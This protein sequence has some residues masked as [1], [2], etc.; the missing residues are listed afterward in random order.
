VLDSGWCQ[1]PRFHG[2][3]QVQ[4]VFICSD[5]MISKCLCN[6]FLAIKQ[7]GRATLACF[8][9]NNEVVY[10]KYHKSI[11]HITVLYLLIKGITV[12]YM[13]NQA[14]NCTV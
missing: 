6:I 3:K 9:E 1:T 12:L 14:N 11:I 7:I 13:P 8:G 4:V 5:E 2:V 10:A